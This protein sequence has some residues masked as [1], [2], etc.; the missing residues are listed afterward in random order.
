MTIKSEK[1]FEMH[2]EAQFMLQMDPQNALNMLNLLPLKIC[3]SCSL[4]S[5]NQKQ[6]HFLLLPCL[7]WVFF[8]SPT[9]FGE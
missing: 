9:R 3:D 4:D 5:Q 8:Y 2:S 7:V 6:K 1:T